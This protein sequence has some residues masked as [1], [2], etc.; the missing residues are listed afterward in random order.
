MRDGRKDGRMEVFTISPSL[1][2]WDKYQHVIKKTKHPIL[3]CESYFNWWIL[4]RDVGAYR[5]SLTSSH[6]VYFGAQNGQF[7]TL[8]QHF[9]SYITFYRSIF[10]LCYIQRPCYM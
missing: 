3:S 7:P 9:K 8:S 1:K 2:C 6:H 10:K 5:P 4:I